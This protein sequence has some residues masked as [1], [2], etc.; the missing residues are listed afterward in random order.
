MAPADPTLDRDALSAVSETLLL[1]LYCRAIES[2]SAAPVLADPKAVAIVEQLD[3]AFAGSERRLHRK[4]IARA[5]PSK[6]TVTMALRTRRFDRYAQAFLQRA[7]DGVIVSLGCGLD[8]RYERIDNGRARWFE[9]DLPEVI[10]WRR[11]FFAESDRRT[12][13]AASATDLGWLEQLAPCRGRPL[14]FLAE[15]LF[16]YLDRDAVQALV[17]ELRRRFPG[18]ELVAE[19]VHARWVTR[20][21]SR[22]IRYKFRKQLH[23]DADVTFRF[24][25]DGSR[26]LESWSPGIAFVDEWTYFDD[27]EPKMGLFNLFG[28]FESL[29]KVQW[30]V[31]YR[32]GS[33]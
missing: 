2:E 28:R 13:I 3:A 19:V 17:C 24:G 9:L 11:R 29:R 32:L 26:A 18:S 33:A 22:W 5:L 27:G 6:L 10:G 16:M 25:I 23:L 1:P 4:L 30:T 7:P 20:M 12:F 21:K 31:H 15:G 14:L 8:T